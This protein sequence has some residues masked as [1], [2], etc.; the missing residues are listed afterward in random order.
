MR[1][2]VDELCSDACAGRATGTPGGERAREVVKAALRDAGLDPAEQPIPRN[3]GVNLL[4]TLEGDSDRYVLVAAHY[5]HLGGRPGAYF[6]GADDNAA[7]V[8]IL[9][10]VARALAARRQDGRGVV[11]AAFDAEEPPHFQSNCMGSQAWVRNATVP[12][13]RV[14]LMICMD[15]VGHAVGPEHAPAEV[16]ESLFVLGAEREKGVVARRIDAEVIPPLSDYLAFWQARVPFAFLTC[17]R[18]QHYHALSDTP[19]KLDYA[20]MAA[21]ARWLEA[22]TRRACARDDARVFTDAPDDAST[23]TSARALCQ[24]LAPVAPEA[25]LGIQ[26]AEGLLAICDRDGRLPEGRRGEAAQLVA[27]LES[28]LA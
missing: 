13:D 1:E 23:L 2:L 7:A 27:L 24:A 25:A 28:R 11:I 10:E 9:V 3:R 20:K 12:L 15:L 16:R 6:R 26:M 5:D 4:A 21:T 17:G 14:D 8:A 18:W 19:E 22:F